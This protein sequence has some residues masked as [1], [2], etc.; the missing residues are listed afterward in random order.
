MALSEKKFVILAR[1]AIDGL[2]APLA[3]ATYKSIKKKQNPMYASFDQISKALAD[4][5]AINEQI[6]ENP[7]DK[8]LQQNLHKLL[9]KQSTITLIIHLEIAFNQKPKSFAQISASR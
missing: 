6:E 7:N 1:E 2:T 9:S 3:K 4:K 5:C 8:S